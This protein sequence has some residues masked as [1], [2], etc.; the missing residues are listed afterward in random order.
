[1]T[2]H[3]HLSFKGLDS[4]KALFRQGE[5]AWPCRVLVFKNR[6]KINHTS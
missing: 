3:P 1:M 6:L 5:E 4:V 2:F